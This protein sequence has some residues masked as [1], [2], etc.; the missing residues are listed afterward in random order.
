M[1]ADIPDINKIDTVVSAILNM[2]VLGGYSRSLTVDP[3]T[4]ETTPDRYLE[5]LSD[6]AS[7]HAVRTAMRRVF[8]HTHYVNGVDGIIT[9]ASKDEITITYSDGE[10]AVFRRAG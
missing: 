5:K 6:Y 9:A 8:E 3:V 10:S 4:G 7:E 2:E 1:S